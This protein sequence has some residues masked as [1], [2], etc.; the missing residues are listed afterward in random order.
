MVC[1]TLSVPCS[2]PYTSQHR[3]RVR[4]SATATTAQLAHIFC[5]PQSSSQ[6]P[7]QVP[8]SLW[9]TH[10]QCPLQ[11]GRKLVLFPRRA[12][13]DAPYSLAGVGGLGNR[14][15]WRWSSFPEPYSS[16]PE[17]RLVSPPGPT[18]RRDREL[19]VPLCSVL[20]KIPFVSCRAVEGR[21]GR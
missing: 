11:V 1:A 9:W 5:P 3:L 12:P 16:L 18:R 4:S 21:E 10:A 7:H 6:L 15:R 2:A 20:H 17:G 14:S 19:T 13:A 8:A